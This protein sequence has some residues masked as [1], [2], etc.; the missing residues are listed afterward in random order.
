MKCP[1][2]K[3]GELIMT[4]IF[5]MAWFGCPECNAVFYSDGY[6]LVEDKIK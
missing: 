3:K 2:C 6:D 5:Y 1:K 4:E